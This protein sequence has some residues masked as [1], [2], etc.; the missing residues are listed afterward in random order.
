MLIAVFQFHSLSV[1]L[2]EEDGFSVGCG[3][4]D[5]FRLRRLLAFEPMMQH[6]LLD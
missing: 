1:F 6:R 2:G 3:R 4:G 5:I